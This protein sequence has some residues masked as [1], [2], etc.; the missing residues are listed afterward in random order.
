MLDE[1]KKKLTVSINLI[2]KTE[3]YNRKQ[4]DRKHNFS[5]FALN[6]GVFWLIDQTQI[7]QVLICIN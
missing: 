2:M 6:C 7:I 1:R 3:K 5:G 4:N